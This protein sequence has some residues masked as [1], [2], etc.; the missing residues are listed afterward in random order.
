MPGQG[1]SWVG[2]V[3]D[4]DPFAPYPGSVI[5]AAIPVPSRLDDTAEP[6]G[7]QRRRPNLRPLVAVSSAFV[8]IATYALFASELLPGLVAV[9]AAGVLFVLLPTDRSFARRVA[10]NGALLLGWTPLLWWVHFPFRI[11]HGALVCAVGAGFATALV[12]RLDAG[13]ARARVLIPTIRAVDSIPVAA[14]A[15]ALA[16]T[17]KWAFASSPQRALE[18]LLPGADNYAHFNLF[19]NLLTSGSTADVAPLP[20]DGSGWAFDKYPAGFHADV[21]TLVEISHPRVPAG[22]ELL[23]SYTHGVAVIVVLGVVLMTAAMVSLP[24]LRARPAIAVPVVALTLIA[25]LYEPGQKVLANGFGNFWLAAVAASCALVLSVAPQRQQSTPQ[26]AAIAGLLILIGHTWAPLLVVAAPAALLI[27]LDRGTDSSGRTERR[28]LL[29]CLSLLILAGLAV[30]K[31]VVV[32][33]ATVDVGVLVTAFG[34]LNGTSP[35]PTFVLIVV[36]LYVCL[37]YPAWVRRFHAEDD[38]V[39]RR[40]RTL[41]LAPFLGACLGVVLLVAQLLTVGTTSYYFLKYLIGFELILAAFAPV[42]CGTLLASVTRPMAKRSGM[43]AAILATLAISQSFGRFPQG[44]PLLL[45]ETDDGTAAIRP[46]FTRSGM[47][48]G[49]LAA[50]AGVERTQTFK[51]EYLPLG[52][53]RAVEAFYPDAW[54]HAVN[55][56]LSYDALSRLAVLRTP[57]N[58]VEQAVPVA[59]TLL[60]ADSGVTIVVSP[61]F[62]DALRK[63]I[64]SDILAERVIAW[65]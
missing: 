13:R 18:A 61:K 29:A 11:D 43:V 3:S 27:L 41:W 26:V 2:E 17:Q 59:R 15:L 56:S 64:G 55:A 16:A 4:R 24:G 32:L 22:P 36:A 51:R 21:A 28:S 57:V 63:G 42:V 31:A 25:Y 7:A 60:E 8:A 33:F 44:D 62:V 12:V 38:G 46:P 37:A 40:L 20:M 54:Y 49:V 10:L 9:C 1:R 30:L 5:H 65:N 45:S 6:A 39:A 34:G 53:G 47:A 14:G 35:A 50:S 58:S 52:T 48:A 19:S 23:V